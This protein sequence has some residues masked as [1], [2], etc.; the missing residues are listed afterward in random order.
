MAER[1]AHFLHLITWSISVAT[2]ISESASSIS[3]RKRMVAGCCL[4]AASSDLLGQKD[5]GIYL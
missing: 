2:G 3:T 5:D 1:Q 4:G